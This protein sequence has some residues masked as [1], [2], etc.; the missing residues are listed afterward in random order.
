MA[1]GSRSLGTRTRPEQELIGCRRFPVEAAIVY[2]LMDAPAT[3]LPQQDDNRQDDM[4]T[5]DQIK[6]ALLTEH[7]RYTPLVS[8]RFYEGGI[9][10][11]LT[12]NRRFWT[13]SSTPSTS[14][15]TRP[16]ARLR[17]RFSMCPRSN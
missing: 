14:S 12:I 2:T 17:L 13:T 3:L 16:S 4:A 9:Y 6:N 1:D 8:V 5:N 7:F 15:F 10:P 11:Q